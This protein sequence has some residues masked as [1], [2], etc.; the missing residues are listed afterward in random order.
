MRDVG[1]LDRCLAQAV[2]DGVKGEFPGRKRHRPLAV[3]DPGE[4][5]FFGGD[6]L[7]VLD[8]ACRR[9]VERRI[10]AQGV[11]PTTPICS[12]CDELQPL[13]MA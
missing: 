4:P 3:L 5:L 13:R 10:D 9:V 7:A 1:E 8:Q 2:V 6:H 12:R 11:H